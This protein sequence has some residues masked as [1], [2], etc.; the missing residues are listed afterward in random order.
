VLDI[1]QDLPA[2]TPDYERANQLHA[3]AKIAAD[4]ITGQLDIEAS[5]LLGL[6]VDL[7]GSFR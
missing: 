3:R 5:K 7:L 6:T 4:G 1:D 2:E